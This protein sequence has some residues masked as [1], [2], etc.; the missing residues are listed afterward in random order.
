[1]AK[2]S[3][4]D[5]EETKPVE[6]PKKA[7]PV[8]K[9]DAKPGESEEPEAKLDEQAKPGEE[10]KPGEEKPADGK[11][12]DGKP[13]KTSPWKLV[14]SYK[15][16]N[17]KLQQEIAELRTS[18]K[19]GELPKE[20]QEKFTAIEARN[21]EL[22][23]EIRFV[24]YSKSK[25][26]VDTYQKPYEEAWVNAISDLKELVI[27]ND[28]G[29]S[30]AATAQDLIALS[31]MP[32]GQ[33][34]VTAKDWFGESADDVMAHRRTIRDL[35][36]KQSKAL[37]DSKTHGSERDQQRA[38][39]MQARHKARSEEAEKVWSQVNAEALE[40]YEYLRPVEGE[41]ERNEKLDKA[42][43]FVDET[44]KKNL[45]QAKTVE[46]RD[47]IIKAHA[48]LR[49]RAVGFSVLKHENVSLKAKVAE[50]EKAIAEF[51]ASEPT[52]G[53]PKSQQNGEHGGGDEMG[54]AMSRLAGS[55]YVT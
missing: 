30:R 13:G 24:N 35:S 32:L 48:A 47:T 18:M 34:R 12:V 25:E 43:K 1:M 31:N 5:E 23:D 52:N 45:G 42:V 6:A 4:P 10:E 19:P 3:D 39:E 51:Q 29:S 36:D 37:E 50:L 28:D 54:A 46:E 8:A 33:A 14:E 17:A 16:T 15:Q 41:V 7:K 26:F 27:T 44:L 22:E 20:H 21:K 2:F 38:A 55:N 40:K 9:T 53:G 49:N 11:P